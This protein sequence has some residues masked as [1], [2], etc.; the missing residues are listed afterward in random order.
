MKTSRSDASHFIEGKLQVA[1]NSTAFYISV[2]CDMEWMAASAVKAIKGFVTVSS[3]EWLRPSHAW[4]VSIRHPPPSSIARCTKQLSKLTKECAPLS[5]GAC[6]N[7]SGHRC[8]SRKQRVSL[9][10]CHRIGICDKRRRSRKQHCL[11]MGTTQTQIQTQIS[12]KHPAFKTS[13]QH[14]WKPMSI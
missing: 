7:T 12:K 6:Q 11:K 1:E 2:L 8:Q 13:S 4:W 14:L 9:A 3:P 10:V 5:A